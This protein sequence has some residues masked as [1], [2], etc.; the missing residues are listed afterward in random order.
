MQQQNL[1]G[2]G[3]DTTSGDPAK[4]QWVWRKVERF[5]IGSMPIM[6]RSELCHL[7]NDYGPTKGQA[8]PAK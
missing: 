2:G 3:L 6:V 8:K 5:K 7:T 4:E 1:L